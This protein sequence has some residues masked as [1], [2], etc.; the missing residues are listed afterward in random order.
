MGGAIGSGPVRAGLAWARP[1]WGDVMLK[2][3]PGRVA[4]GRAERRGDVTKWSN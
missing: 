1:G 3:P 4:V 2:R